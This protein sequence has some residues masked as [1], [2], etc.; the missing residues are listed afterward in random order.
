MN[1]KQGMQPSETMRLLRAMAIGAAAALTVIA[2]ACLLCA[3]LLDR[4]MIPEEAAGIL[5]VLICVVGSAAGALLSQHLAGRARLPVSLGSTA[6]LLL[7][8]GV[9]RYA[10]R[11]GSAFSWRSLPAAALS[12]VV[13]ALICAGR[14]R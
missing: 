9:V 8:L 5:T 3:L 12:A 7:A 13:C 2:S 6:L 4:Q 11:S 1:A 14:G 10:L